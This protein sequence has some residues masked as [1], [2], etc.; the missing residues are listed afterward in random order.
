MPAVINVTN[1]EIAYTEN[2]L[3]PNGQCFDE[4]RRV[5]IKNFDTI[6]LQAVPG[7]GKTTALL[8][9]LLILEK[10]L[11]FENGSGILVISHTNAAIYEIKNKI[12]IFCPKLF[13]YPNFVGTIQS[14][15]DAYLAIPYYVNHF[16]SKPYR[17]DEEI[18]NEKISKYNLPCKANLWVNKKRNPEEYLTKIRFDDNLNLIPE[19]NKTSKDFE[20]KD[21]KKDSYKALVKMKCDLLKWGYLHYDDAYLL[22]NIYLKKFPHII[23]IIQTRFQYVFVDEMQDMDKHQHDLLEALF[24]KTNNTISNYQRIGDKNQAIFNGSA[25]LDNIWIDRDTTLE[26]K[27]S[28]R[29]TKE[30]ADIV[31]CF[32]LQFI[33]IEGRY[34]NP[35]GTNI[36]PHV[37]VFDDNSIV[38]VVP[39]F[40]NI[41]Q[42]FETEGKIPKTNKN[43]YKVIAWRKEKTGD[44]KLGLESYWENFDD[45]EHR[46]KE[47]HSCIESYL[48]HH[49]KDKKTLESVS[50]HIL[51][52]LLRILRYE[53]ILDENNNNYTKKKLLFILKERNKE[54]YE[55]LRLLLYQWSINIIRGK[56]TDVYPELKNYISEFV[57]IFG[58]SIDKSRTFI[59]TP[60]NNDQVVG[61]Y[62]NSENKGNNIYKKDGINIEITTI[63]SIK[64]QTHT[65]TLYLETFYEREYE[66]ERLAEQFKGNNFNN[67]GIYSRQTTKMA[68][69][70]LSRPNYLLCLA[71]HKNRFKENVFRDKWEIIDISK[72]DSNLIEFHT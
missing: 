64:G 43:I 63:H 24:I 1:D 46:I 50:K 47:D 16:R 70:G 36:K 67:T 26:L 69:V 44:C 14:F 2:I 51:N 11:P 68:Y 34:Q 3:L 66:S 35:T 20:L 32:A 33:D 21:S 52:A 10:R 29:L 40:A 58:K 48:L 8:A 5:F 4:E 42:R 23:K 60:S 54:Q 31:K 45:N 56:K 37:I 18:Y 6:D 62:K 61:S 59:E 55:K 17:I 7:S 15:V 27:G 12:A 22:A 53:N 57:G 39:A 28:Y 19:L 13:S 25:K 41:I 9:K 65:A 30:F 49:D 72:T 71:V 38:K